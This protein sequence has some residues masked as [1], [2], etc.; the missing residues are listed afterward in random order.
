M[1]LFCINFD[2]LINMSYCMDH[3]AVNYFR[4]YGNDTVQQ[5]LVIIHLQ[6][7]THT[8]I[9]KAHAGVN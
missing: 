9:N 1:L 7:Y 2:D 4:V 8:S 6:S 5:L 3:F